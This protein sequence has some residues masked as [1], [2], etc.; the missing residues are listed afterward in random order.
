MVESY[1]WLAT[2][3]LPAGRPG[4]L[5]AAHPEEAPA[6][7][8]LDRRDRGDF[9]RFFYRRYDGAPV[10]QIDDDAASCS[11]QLL[12]TKSFPAAIRRVREHRAL[13][14]RTMLITGAL[15]FVVGAAAAAVRRGDRGR[16]AVRPDGTYTGELDDGAAHR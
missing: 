14:H 10:G 13:G 6:L 3:R 7:L 15:D 2:R 12:L 1:S 8:A 5:R 16:D 11:A 9:L 4:A